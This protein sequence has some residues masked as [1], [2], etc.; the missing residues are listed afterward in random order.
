MPLLIAQDRNAPG[1][2]LG[3]LSFPRIFK[4]FRTISAILELFFRILL[5]SG[6]GWIT[7]LP[8]PT[9]DSHERDSKEPA[10]C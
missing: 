6:A 5:T 8:S 10:R 7:L 3:A 9:G 1:M 4:R 2:T